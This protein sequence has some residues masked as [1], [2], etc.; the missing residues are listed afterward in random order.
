ML[1]AL[2]GGV[3]LTVSHV[4][5]EDGSHVVVYGLADDEPQPARPT[6]VLLQ[7]SG[8]NSVFP[9]A[10][11]RTSA[12]LLF[13]ALR[14]LRAEWNVYFVEKRGVD[15]GQGEPEGGARAASTEYRRGACYQERVAD[16][17]HALDCLTAT[18][19]GANR[20]LLLIGSS[21]GSDIAAGVAARHSA[22]THLAL[23]PFSAGHGLFDSLTGLRAEFARGELS[24]AEFQE[25]YDWLVETFRGI[26]ATA[27]DG[28]EGYLWGHTHQRWRSH[29]SGEVL[30]D[31]LHV[32]S[33]VFLGIPSLDRC[34]GIDLA[35]A[36][37]VR[38]GKTNLTYRNYPNYDHGF[39]EHTGDRVECR[40]ADVLADI[41]QWLASWS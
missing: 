15:F 33:P 3:E 2:G 6:I 21:E 34:E 23:L 17:C 27:G 22:P 8:A 31:L 16:V 35:V 38:Q 7:C 28:A 24:P 39:F 4:P 40:H 26:L 1:V 20:P 30:A 32:E 29:C 10:E 37:F 12:P 14:A 13:H 5:R 36:E 25:Q 9:C 11:G 41:L 19:A 18:H